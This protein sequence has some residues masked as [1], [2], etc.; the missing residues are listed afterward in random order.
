M[1]FCDPAPDEDKHLRVRF[2]WHGRPYIATLADKVLV[3]AYQ[4]KN[5]N[6]TFRTLSGSW[7]RRFVTV[8]ACTSLKLPGCFYILHQT[9]SADQ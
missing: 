8:L 9:C 6:D 4:I 1:G 5:M 3:T 7:M 2:L